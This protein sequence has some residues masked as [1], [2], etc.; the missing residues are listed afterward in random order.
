MEPA[1]RRRVGWQELWSR[2][3]FELPDAIQSTH[4]G[5]A[6][7]HQNRLGRMVISQPAQSILAGAE[8]PAHP[9]PGVWSSEQARSPDRCGL[10]TREWWAAS[11]LP[12]KVAAGHGAE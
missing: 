9:R 2:T 1:P 10:A 6:D 7:I 12:L 4:A 8:G 5:Q 3:G 11:G